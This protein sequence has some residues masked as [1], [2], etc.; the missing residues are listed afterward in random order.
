MLF[1]L[2]EELNS[3][4]PHTLACHGKI[5]P[6]ITGPPTPNLDTKTDQI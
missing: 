6:S 4:V 3:V 2:D 1:A 5:A